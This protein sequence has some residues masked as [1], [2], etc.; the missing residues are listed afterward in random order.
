MD[1][2]CISYPNKTSRNLQEVKNGTLVNYSQKR[3]KNK[4]N[5]EMKIALV[6]LCYLPQV[7]T[8]ASNNFCS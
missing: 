5:I 7:I 6:N 4:N 8:P 3:L 1:P 2:Y